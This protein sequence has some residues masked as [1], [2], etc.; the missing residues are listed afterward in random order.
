MH[1]RLESVM[2][3]ALHEFLIFL[4]GPDGKHAPLFEGGACGGNSTL[5]VELEVTRGGKCAWAVVD[6]QQDGIELVSRC[7][8]G[9]EDI[10]V[11]KL[12]AR[13]AKRMFGQ[14]AEQ[15]AIPFHYGRDEFGDDNGRFWRKNIERGTQRETHP[16]TANQNA[17]AL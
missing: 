3:Q 15:S 2:A 17:G 1:V 6:V 11:L 12:Y 7:A 16:Q 4:G 9:D 14:G 5:G 13:I 10:R 8:E